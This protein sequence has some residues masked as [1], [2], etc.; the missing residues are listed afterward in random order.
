MEASDRPQ[1]CANHPLARL[2]GDYIFVSGTS[3]RWP[4]NTFDVAKADVMG[5]ATLAI[6]AQ[7]R[8]VIEGIRTL[9]TGLGADLG[10]LVDVTCCLVSMN[11]FGGFNEVY[12][13]YFDATTGQAHTTVA[14]H[15]LSHPHNLL[16]IRGTAFKPRIQLRSVRCP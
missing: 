14:V 10:G 8:S 6:R 4:D 5:T 1:P 12:N 13:S 3:A 11:D 16:E 15:Q 9:L 2:A 7:T